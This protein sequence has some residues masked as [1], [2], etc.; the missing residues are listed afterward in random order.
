MHRVEVPVLI[1]GAGG[2]GLTTAIALADL[3]V[4]ALLVERHA[5]TS[6]LPKAHYVNQRAMEIFRQHGVADAIYAESA[7]PDNMSK[8]Y[9]MTSLG[10]DGPLDRLIIHEQDA[11]GS[12]PSIRGEYDAKGTT[13]PTNIPQIRLEP[14]LRAAA[15]QHSNGRLWFRHEAV[16]CDQDE[17]GVTVLVRDLDGGEEIEVRCRY[18]VA[19]DAGRT[20]APA[21]GIESKVFTLGT[22][23]AVVWIAADLSDYVPNDDAVMRFIFHPDRPDR[24]GGL[25]AFG[26]KHWD[27]RSEEWVIGFTLDRERLSTDE[28]VV[29]E[30]RDFIR[31]DVPFDVRAITYWRVATRIAE[32]FSRGRVFLIGDAAHQHPPTGGLGL[33]SAI[34]DAHNLA[35]KLALVLNGDASATLLS[36]YDVERRSVIEEN[37]EWSLATHSSYFAILSALGAPPGASPAMTVPSFTELMSETRTGGLR[38][39]ILKEVLGI[40]RTEYAAHDLEMG[41]RYEAGALV[42]DGT[43][44]PDRDPM[45]VHYQP[46]SR[47]G[48]RLPHAWIHTDGGRVSTHDLIPMGGFLLL[49]GDAAMSW[50]VAAE[51]V[52]A[53]RGLSLR[54]I[55]VGPN[56]AAQDPS[57]TWDDVSEI[58]ADGAILA[59]PDAHVAFRSSGAVADPYRVLSEAFETILGPLS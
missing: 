57:G 31:A 39:G 32:T 41:F 56:S 59:R 2:G 36:T 20:I 16:S 40:Q 55:C 27:R 48:S 17:S 9:W 42:G 54:A 58:S 24:M 22:E 25:L 35:W 18:L 21:L 46:T 43:A 6:S 19:A 10:G 11:L 26:P 29:A 7:P 51:K 1:V 52:A 4:E 8:V 13:R 14:I 33:N 23:W 45:G 53:D 30:A 3:G 12:G 28:A 44:P 15:E 5:A 37:I 50:C 38:R 47:P 34:H 49:G